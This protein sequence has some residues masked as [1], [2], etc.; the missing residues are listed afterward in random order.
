[1]GLS[2]PGVR[3]HTWGKVGNAL[4]VEIQVISIGH[5][6]TIVCL[7]GEVFVDLAL[8]IKRGSPFRTTLIMELSNYAETCYIPTARRMPRGAMR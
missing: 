3:T 6:L 5:D 8:A 4:P 1:M 2:I 7:P